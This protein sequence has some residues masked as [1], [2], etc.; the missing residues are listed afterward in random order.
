MAYRRIEDLDEPATVGA[1][2]NVPMVRL[3]IPSRWCEW[4]FK[5]LVPVIGS[6]H[7]DAEFI[8][9]PQEHWH[10]DWRFVSAREFVR[11]SRAA[12]RRPPVEVQVSKVITVDMVTGGICRH[13]RKCRR[14][15]VEF[16][17]LINGGRAVP[18]IGA[19]EHAF[20]D[21]NARC[22]ICPHRGI[23]LAGQPVKDGAR[24]CPGHGLRW[25]VTTGALVPR[26]AQIDAPAPNFV[27]A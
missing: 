25:N 14:L 9:F 16:P 5:D 7:E 19:L 13:V 22:G 6:R 15:P 21:Q 26:L 10:I 20:A 2:Y 4:I 3:L 8:S 24:V 1:L 11:V 17:Y 27:H 12:R 18:W 23:P